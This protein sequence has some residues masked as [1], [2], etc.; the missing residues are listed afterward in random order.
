M[1]VYRDRI[2]IVTGG[3]SGIGRALGERLAVLGATVTLADVDEPRAAEVARSIVEGGGRARAAALDVRDAAAV[4]A[5]VEATAA[6]HG[7]LDYMFNNAGIGIAGDVLGMSLADWDR[8]VDVNLKGVIHGVVG[9]YE[10]M[11][12]QRSGHIVNTA[13][14]AGLIPS[15]GLT[16]YAATKHAV[17]GLSTS[18]RAEAARHGV[19]VT[20]VCPGLIETPMK[21]S[22]KLLDVDRD[23]LMSQVPF[24]FYP[25]ERCARDILRGVAKNRPVVVVTGHARFLALVQRL[26]PSLVHRIARREATTGIIAKSRT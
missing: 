21:Q 26:F 9:A 14:V 2:A 15:P 11:A 24:A 5:L 10:L 23:K 8:I 4:R 16:A 3:A 1:D 13:S 25:A 6:E 7:R 18:L 19:K 22:I 17:V 20:A 12:R